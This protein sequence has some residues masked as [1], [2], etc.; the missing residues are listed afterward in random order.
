M[1][2]TKHLVYE[3]AN[4]AVLQCDRTELFHITLFSQELRL[5]AC[6]FIAF[7]KK[8]QDLDFEE[9]F[10]DNHPGV[11][12]VYLPFCDKLLVFSLKEVIELKDLFS[13]SFAMLELNSL[14]N[15]KLQ[16]SLL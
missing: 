6:Q 11:E 7:R 16:N 14:I 1:G 3:T 13:G 8:I 12:I 4:T 2:Q 10:T 5:S 15:R 9:L